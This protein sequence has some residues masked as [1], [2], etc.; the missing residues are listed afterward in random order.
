MI[1][2]PGHLPRAA[3][4]IGDY[5]ACPFGY[6]QRPKLSNSGSHP[7]PLLPQVHPEPLIE[8]FTTQPTMY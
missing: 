6:P 4:G 1:E 5:E 3:P 8:S 2:V 7:F